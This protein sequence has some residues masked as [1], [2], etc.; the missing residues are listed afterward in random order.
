M[1]LLVITQKVDRDDDVL[2]FFHTWLREL[3]PLFDEL[4]VIALHR[5][6]VDLP[7]NVR[8]AT[9]GKERNSPKWIQVLRF[10]YNLVRLLP[11]SDGVFCHM[12]PDYVLAIYPLNLIF[13]KRVILW[14]AHVRVGS[15]A[16]WA[17]S[18]V[19][20]VLSPSRDSFAVDT[21]NLVAAG[22]GIDTERFRPRDGRLSSDCFELLSVNRISQV[23]DVDVLVEAVNLL[24]HR[25]GFHAFR[26]TVVGG[27]ARPEDFAYFEELKQRAHTLALEPYVNWVGPVPY[28]EIVPFFHRAHAFVR[29]QGGGGFSKHEL[30]ALACGLPVIVC[31]PIYREVFRDHQ[32]SLCWREKDPEDLA[33]K[34]RATA[35]WTEEHR[36]EFARWARSYVTRN[37][38]L[39]KLVRKIAAEFASGLGSA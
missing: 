1:N 13:R 10:Y 8:V 28:R 32:A 35:T 3:A 21:G 16:A 9:L 38:D 30:E 34:I 39:K 18:K 29:T 15:R 22:H 26:V 14:Y 27:P 37:H 23:K 17:A 4:N 19:Y 5:G 2:G 20:R 36:D 31:A 12:S 33:D 6:S 11:R 7:A 25:H 24:V